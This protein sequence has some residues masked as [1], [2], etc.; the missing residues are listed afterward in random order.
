M[1]YKDLFEN[2]TIKRSRIN[3]VAKHAKKFNH[4]KIERDRKTNYTRK[5]RQAWK[6][7]L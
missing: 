1:K 4:S 2:D 3:Y 5:G 7:E 6:K